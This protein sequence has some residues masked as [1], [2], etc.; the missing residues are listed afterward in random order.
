MSINVG[1]M[2]KVI[3]QD[4]VGRVVRVYP[5]TVVIEDESL[6]L[7]DNQLEFRHYEVTKESC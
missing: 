6:E 7:E 1:D 5:T 4:I 2:V 3:G